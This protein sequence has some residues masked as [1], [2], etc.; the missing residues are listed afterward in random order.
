MDRVINPSE[1]FLPELREELVLYRSSEPCDG[2]MSWV[3]HDRGRNRFFQVSWPEFEIL[4]RWKL[5]KPQAVAE[6]VNEQTTLSVSTEQVEEVSR[7]LVRNE[8]VRCANAGDV[9]RLYQS[10]RAGEQS[11]WM[12][13]L[14]H[15]LFFRI[16]LVRPDRFLQR[17]LPYV[18]FLFQP[19]F[20][21]LLSALVLLGFYLVSRQWDEFLNTFQHFYSFEG[22]LVFAVAL[23]FSKIIHELGHAYAAKHYG[24]RVPT[25]GVA[26]LVMWPV[27]YTDTSDGWKLHDRRQRFTIGIAGMTAE[28]TLAAL[29]LLGWSMTPEGPVNSA[30]F[31]LASSTWILTLVVN[32]N[33]LMRFD[34]YYLF[35]DYL[36]IKNL[37]ER[38]FAMARWKLRS[39]L[40][41][42]ELPAPEQLRAKTV[43]T[44]V[45]FAWATWIYRF[46]LFLAIA[47]LVYYFF[48]KLAGLLLMVIELAWF[49]V[50]PVVREL[51]AWK[52]LAKDMTLNRNSVFVL[53]ALLGLV[54]LLIVPWQTTV[55][56]PAVVFA[57]QQ[58][59][60][61][62]VEP[63]RLADMPVRNQQHVSQGELLFRLASDE[64]AF[65]LQKARKE[66]EISRLQL[67]RAQ[68]SEGDVEQLLVARQRLLEAEASLAG[69]Q[70]Q[71]A[72]LEIRAPFAGKLLEL[73]D[74]IYPGVYLAR[75][76]ELA[77][78]VSDS[79]LVIEAY[80]FEDHA[81]R[82]PEQP[83]EGIFYPAIADYP[84]L[85]LQMLSIDQRNVLTLEHPMLTSVYEGEVPSVRNDKGELVPESVVYRATFSPVTEPDAYP[86]QKIR[87]TVHLQA[88]KQSLLG[89]MW[90]HV[91]MVFLRESGF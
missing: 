10:A 41:G 35:S 14:R 63:G 26:F 12:Q 39:T 50:M 75:D 67:E 9:E 61:Y 72:R 58:S 32:L 52:H 40:F 48:F 66:Q 62:P 31:I 19:L 45:I 78:L 28:I 57:R 29:A 34:G 11:V 4:S 60:L 46:F 68:L 36:G 74:D 47:L 88:Q 44:L 80:I 83:G 2:S 7:F 23:S 42:L 5:K 8:L 18:R 22:I 3:I 59:T 55:K 82:L 16:P 65:R 15:Y 90:N 89:R 54:V 79:G 53:L 49:I 77:Q 13:A 81:A 76:K 6:R 86:R 69:L 84:P 87:G 38:A 25:I 24:L 91:V 27:L 64:L 21:Y 30:L 43:R 70:D 37:Q 20:L 17:T 71:F 56:V 85:A 1:N 33:P 51:L 73:A